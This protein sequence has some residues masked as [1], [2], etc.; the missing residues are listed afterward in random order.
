MHSNY[1][2]GQCIRLSTECVGLRNQIGSTQIAEPAVRFGRLSKVNKCRHKSV[3]VLSGFGTVQALLAAQAD[4][5]GGE[6]VVRQESRFVDILMQTG[7]HLVDDYHH[8]EQEID[9]KRPH[10]ELLKPA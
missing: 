4:I 6:T 9:S 10:H 2:R 8:H 1:T 3:V 5:S 7:P